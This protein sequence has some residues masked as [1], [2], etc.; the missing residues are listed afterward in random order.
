ML[1]KHFG[2]G[3]GVSTVG[4]AEIS[5]DNTNTSCTPSRNVRMM[6]SKGSVHSFPERGNALT[7]QY[8]RH[9]D[10]SYDTLNL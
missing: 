1:H 10:L 6:Q 3:L 2:T 5:C 4:D 8:I 7:T 9:H